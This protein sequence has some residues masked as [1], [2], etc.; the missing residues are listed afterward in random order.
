MSA[1]VSITSGELTSTH[2]CLKYMEVSCHDGQCVK[3][4]ALFLK[5][6]VYLCRRQSLVI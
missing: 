1:V 2:S 6:E 5:F 4:C 3:T